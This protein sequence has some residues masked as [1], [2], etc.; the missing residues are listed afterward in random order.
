MPR[1]NPGMKQPTLAVAA[2]LLAIGTLAAAQQPAVPAPEAVPAAPRY[3][4]E[5][6]VF[7][8]REFDA[9]EESFAQPAADIGNA[10]AQLREPP[11]FDDTN[12]GPLATPVAPPVAP[13]D[14]DVLPDAAAEPVEPTFRMLLPAELQLNAEYQ[15]LSRLPAYAPLLHA[16]WVQ[17][18]LP[19]N[20][21]PTFDLA[22]LGSLN[23]LGTVRLYLSRFLHV[24][25]DLTY[26]GAAA[27]ASAAQPTGLGEFTLAPRYKLET[28]RNVRSGELHYFDHPAF[29][30]LVKITPLP[31]QSGA[32]NTGR[33]PAA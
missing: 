26:Q 8:N 24:K 33:R 30:V 9:S 2:I 23:P 29:G 17:A 5:I 11:V 20:Q 32:G 16:G 31:A 19:E 1:Y 4:V 22:T 21:A 12:F 25:L 6:I 18:G 3:Q 14:G 28:E 7:A 15:R 10:D 27:A 13:L